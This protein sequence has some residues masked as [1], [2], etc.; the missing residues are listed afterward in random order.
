MVSK[1]TNCVEKQIYKTV[2]LQQNFSFHHE[3][4]EGN[5]REGTFDKKQPYKSDM[6][7][8]AGFCV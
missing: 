3:V 2:Y 1:K 7:C 8:L 4:F 6:F 5:Q